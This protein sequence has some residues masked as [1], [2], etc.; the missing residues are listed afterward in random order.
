MARR[1][2]NLNLNLDVRTT[3]ANS[4]SSTPLLNDYLIPVLRRKWL[5]TLLCIRVH[6]D[7]P[8]YV[9]LFQLVLFLF[10]WLVGGLVS[11][12]NLS[13]IAL[14]AITGSVVLVWTLALQLLAH[15]I[16]SRNRIQT[17]L[18]QT[19]RRAPGSEEDEIDFLGPFDVSTIEFVL[20][21]RIPG[22]HAVPYAV[23]GALLVGG[24]AAFLQPDELSI[25]FSGGPAAGVYVFGWLATLLAAYGL[26]TQ[27]PPEPSVYRPHHFTEPLSRGVHLGALMIAAYAIDGHA[28]YFG[29]LRGI[30]IAVCLLPLAWALGLLPPLAALV[31][32]ALEQ[33][34]VRILGGS[35]AATDLR[36]LVSTA[37][38]T[39][40]TVLVAHLYHNNTATAIGIAAAA[41]FLLS[42]DVGRYAQRLW[43]WA[44]PP[45]RGNKIHPGGLDALLGPSSAVSGSNEG[46]LLLTLAPLCAREFVLSSVLL[47]GAICSAV[48]PYQHV[49]PGSA[50]S[51]DA[52]AAIFW[53]VWAI[54]VLLRQ[55]QSVY[56]FGLVRNPVHPKAGT[57]GAARAMRIQSGLG[58]AHQVLMTLAPFL[59]IVFVCIYENTS[60]STGRYVLAA[61]LVRALRWGWQQSSDALLEAAVVASIVSRA[62]ASSRWMELPV[63][64]QLLLVSLVWSR[65]VDVVRKLEFVLQVGISSL[66]IKKLQKPYTAKLIA[67]NAVFFPVLLATVVVAAGLAAPILPL[68]G[69]PL[70]FLSYSR[71]SKFWPSGFGTS[72][73]TDA[74][75]Y[76]Q[77]LPSVARLLDSAPVSGALGVLSPGDMLL[78]RF[79]NKMIVLQVL[80]RGFNFCSVVIKGLELQETSCHTEEATHVETM[81]DFAFEDGASSSTFNKY[82]GNILTPVTTSTIDGLS[83][84]RNVLTGVI[85]SPTTL[86]SIKTCFLFVATYRLRHLLASSKHRDDVVTWGKAGMKGKASNLAHLFPGTWYSFLCRQNQDVAV[87]L[88]ALIANGHGTATAAGPGR[89]NS[90]SDWSDVDDILGEG[91]ATMSRAGV[92]LPRPS[93]T[94]LSSSAGMSAAATESA[95]DRTTILTAAMLLYTLCGLDQKAPLTT[96]GVARLFKG[97]LPA[98][99]ASSSPSGSEMFAVETFR[100][101][102][103]LALDRALMGD[104]ETPTQDEYDEV[105]GELRELCQTWYFGPDDDDAWQRAVLKGTPNL[106]SLYQDGGSS[107]VC[108][109]HLLSTQKIAIRVGA[110]NPETVRGIW[111]S[112]N[113]EL[114]FMSN[115]DEERYSIQA[116]RIILRNLMIQTAEPPLGYPIFSAAP[117]SLAD[118]RP[119]R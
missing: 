1:A 56:L 75:Y 79:Q 101:A 11:L 45:Q 34:L 87:P 55:F 7:A 43:N 80:E 66:K 36:L 98:W 71:P 27:A 29:A 41:G 58:I 47:A 5:Q 115:D 82:Y 16:R 95:D 100:I 92:R 105:V 42:L 88:Q 116:H 28:D 44:R 60:S 31:P 57:P 62:D 107:S 37:V 81:F 52:F 94:A 118:C 112:L 65:M 20:P 97:Q 10:P 110:L 22:W 12:A 74:A 103:K 54:G 70:F 32:W 13:R 63:S 33:F 73:S 99:G 40:V 4:T 6:P 64:L 50:S 21:K 113:M 67:L 106:F 72:P 48:L 8:V 24:A 53:V 85:D 69:L 35:P 61:G 19:H 108:H 91:D 119:L 49:H 89:K 15:R 18:P 96:A 83:D 25:Y 23:A 90:S 51:V 9:Y 26:T 102:V 30:Y 84:T 111:A 14:G 2:P 68:F 76:E 114:L 77:V 86:D 59:V 39:A 46:G 109:S 78:M 93:M 17:I 38:A 104:E 117:L 3:A